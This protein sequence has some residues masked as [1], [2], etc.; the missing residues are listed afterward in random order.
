[1]RMFVFPSVAARHEKEAEKKAMDDVEWESVASKAKPADW[2]FM[3]QSGEVLNSVPD[4][5]KKYPETDEGL[6]N[7]IIMEFGEL[8]K[9][10]TKEQKSHELVHLASACLHLWR[11]YH[12]IK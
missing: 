7:I 5:W 11:H 2:D 8:S 12:A 4:T 10:T 6:M 9:A 1:M 3:K